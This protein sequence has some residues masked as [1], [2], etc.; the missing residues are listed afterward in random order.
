MIRSVWGRWSMV[1]SCW[2]VGAVLVVLWLLS[3]S[4]GAAGPA[5]PDHNN[6]PSGLSA[7]LDDDFVVFSWTAPAGD[8]KGYVVYRRAAVEG[9]EQERIGTTSGSTV[10]RDPISGLTPGVQYFYRVKAVNREGSLGSWGWFSN[11]ATAIYVPP[12]SG[13]SAVLSADDVVF[14]WTAPARDLNGYVVYRRAALKGDEYEQIGTT[15]STLFRD[16]STVFRDRVSGLSPGFEYYYRVKAV[17]RI[18]SLRGWGSGSNFAAVTTPAPSGLSTVINDKGEV[19]VSWTAPQGHPAAYAVYRREAVKGDKYKR[20]DSVLSRGS[21]GPDTF[22]VAN[23][24]QLKSGVEYYYRVRA[25]DSMGRVGGW[26]SGSNYAAVTI[27]APRVLSAVFN[28]YY[29]SVEVSWTAPIAISARYEV[30]RRAAVKGT[31]YQLIGTTSGDNVH[32]TVFRDPVSG[33]TPGVEYYYRIKAVNHY[34]LLGSWGSGSNYAA[35]IYTP[36]PSG[37]SA[38]LGAGSVVVS[39][40]APPGHPAGYAVYRRAAVEGD[41]YEQIGTTSG[42]TVLRDPVS[43]LS[44]G[45][46]YYYRVKAVDR[47]GSS[48]TWGPGSNYADVKIP[49]SR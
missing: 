1:V 15:S 23:A 47:R 6:A 19:V 16:P 13:L 9:G 27:P 34:E 28:K 39:W 21:S 22:Y 25:V 18:G 49:R 30:Y 14:S 2:F 4:V 46:E 41:G 31:E 40:T 20:I 24:S 32:R 33:L 7:V 17:D 29:D 42:S 38:V 5:T 37:L 35:A 44:P 8:V 43:R 48:G 12:P 45:V 10:F 36:P 26:G 3:V 11:Y